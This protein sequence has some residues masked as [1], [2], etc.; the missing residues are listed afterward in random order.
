MKWNQCV[1]CGRYIGYKDFD[2][3]MVVSEFIPDT[4]YSRE[5]TENMHMKCWE[6]LN[7]NVKRI[8]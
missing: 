4:I 1:Y 8:L 3:N 2:N 5:K 7:E 6:K